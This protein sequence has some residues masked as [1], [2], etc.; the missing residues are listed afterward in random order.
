MFTT[1]FLVKMLTH[2]FLDKLEMTMRMVI[3]SL[4]RI[5][6]DYLNGLTYIKSNDY[7]PFYVV[8]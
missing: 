5:A 7:T 2:N 3:S 1:K 6:A 8:K 4:S